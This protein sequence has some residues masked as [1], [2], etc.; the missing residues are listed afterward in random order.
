MDTK[1]LW[2][3]QNVTAECRYLIATTRL[4]IEDSRYLLARLRLVDIRWRSLPRTDQRNCPAIDIG[5]WA[6]RGC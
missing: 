5:G 3:L 4:E 1:S 6:G 2:H